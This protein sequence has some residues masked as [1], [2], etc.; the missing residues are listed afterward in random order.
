MW[1]EGL[2]QK[3]YLGEEN[4]VA[5]MQALLARDQLKSYDVPRIQRSGKVLMVAEYLRQNMER[6]DAIFLAYQEGKHTMSAIAKETGLS[7]SRVSRLI[8]AAEGGA[9]GKT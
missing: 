9:K 3:I 8:A 4:F 1:D 5:R 6:N 2:R 7:V